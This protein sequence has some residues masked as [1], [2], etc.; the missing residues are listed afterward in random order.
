MA[1]KMMSVNDLA[2][3]AAAGGGFRIDASMKSTDDLARI[4]AA[5]GNGGGLVTFS[6]LS[7]RSVDE[8]ARI[9]AAGKGRVILED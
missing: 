6:G 4:A 9:A 5:A 7:R 2:R 8:L 3:V 1:F